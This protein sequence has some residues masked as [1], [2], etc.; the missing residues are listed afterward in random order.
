LPYGVVVPVLERDPTD[1]WLRVNYLGYDG[2]IIAF[3][4]RRMLNLSS[5]PVN[6]SF[7]SPLALNVVVIPPEVQRAQIARLREFIQ[8][9]LTAAQNL[10]I[11][12][13]LVYKG[14]IM[15][16]TP[17][18]FETEFTYTVQ[19]LRELPEFGR[20]VPRI[21]QGIAYLNTAIDT[22]QACGEVSP[23]SVLTA[24]NAA[25][26]ARIIFEEGLKSLDRTEA[27]IR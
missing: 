7:R 6:T 10:E 1:E 22:L 16:C 5:V 19:D 8:P 2:W 20:Y 15:P 24:R 13:Q 14:E 9:R 11:F 12:W 21:N 3:T 26:N 18:A 25:T 17:P 27:E 4:T 23:E